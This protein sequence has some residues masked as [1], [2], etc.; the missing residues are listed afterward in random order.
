[1]TESSE[2]TYLLQQFIY[3][4]AKKYSLKHD[5]TWMPITFH[6]HLAEELEKML[7][8]VMD[9]NQAISLLKSF[10]EQATILYLHQYQRN[11]TPPSQA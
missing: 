9:E 4:V 2:L 7:L 3:G 8:N 1:M 10:L 5:T 6:F 11:K